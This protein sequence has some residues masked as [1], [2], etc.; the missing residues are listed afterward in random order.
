MGRVSV[1]GE[2]RDKMP[3]VVSLFSGLGGLDLGLE[4]AG[5]DCVFATDLDARAIESLRANQ[6]FPLQNGA[7]FLQNAQIERADIRNLAGTAILA[8]AG[9]RRGDI[10]LLAGGPPCQS[11]SSAGHQLGFDDPR[12]RLIGEYLRVA[13]ELDCRYLLFENVRGLVTARGPDGVPGS[14]LSWLRDQLFARGWQTHVELLNA[15]DYGVP[16]RRVRVVLIGYRAGDTPQIPAPTHAKTPSLQRLPWRTLGDC[17]AELG[18]PAEE[19]I[20]RPTGKL[21][22]ELASIPPGSGVKSPGKREATR[23]G[24]HW[25]YKQG[26]FV[27]DT[28]LPSRTVTASAQQDWVKDPHLGLRKLSPRECAALQTF[29]NGWVI[30]GSRSDQYRLVGNAVPP[31]LAHAVGTALLQSCDKVTRPKQWATV[32]PLPEQ[33]RSAIEYTQREER[34]N[35]HSR[36]VAPLKRRVRQTV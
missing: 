33:L 1:A 31:Q 5:W 23:P 34:R 35:G 13:A 26:A 19:E 22:V 2:R 10:A 9:R 7:R 3:E 30:A 36:R 17:L 27:A 11:W 18:A 12:G 32:A 8:G 20:I 4:A 14:A 29:P 25:G 28:S 16:Q 24:G 21:A 15:A 6:G